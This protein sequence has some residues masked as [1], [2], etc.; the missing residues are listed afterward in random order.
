MSYDLQVFNESGEVQIDGILSNYQ[1]GRSLVLPSG[2]K[3][4][5]IPAS[6][7][8]I[9]PVGS[10]TLHIASPV[11]S[12]PADPVVKSTSGSFEV[13]EA[14]PVKNLPDS[15]TDWG[16]QVFSE[17]GSKV[18][19]SGYPLLHHTGFLELSGSNTA[20]LNTM[21]SQLT[22]P[23]PSFSRNR[24]INISFLTPFIILE[25]PVVCGSVGGRLVS[26]FS[27]NFNSSSTILTTGYGDG[28]GGWVPGTS[29]ASWTWY[30]YL[31]V[32]DM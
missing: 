20:S 15:G 22:L 8:Y 5:N 23:T 19:D 4:S 31:I 30:Q 25:A 11:C 27:V 6:Y 9:R 21:V 24:Y 26:T 29:F 7:R 32:V 3:L 13:V 1:K 2:T 10:G 17:D 12:T 14:V 16:L 18:Y 28:P